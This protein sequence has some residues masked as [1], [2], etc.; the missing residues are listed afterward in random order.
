MTIESGLRREEPVAFTESFVNRALEAA[1]ELRDA[2]TSRS[3]QSTPRE[4]SA[5]ARNESGAQWRRN[6]LAG[7]FAV[8]FFVLSLYW[9]EP[10]WHDKGH[11]HLSKSQESS[12]QPL[13]ASSS[14]SVHKP[15]EPDAGR[16]PVLPV[17]NQTEEAPLSP[18]D[19]FAA[20]DEEMRNAIAQL[21]KDEAGLFIASSLSKASL[22]KVTEGGSKRGPTDEAAAQRLAALT[23][24]KQQLTRETN[25][26][27]GPLEADDVAM[28][29][30]L[31]HRG[32][33]FDHDI[34]GIS[35]W[36]ARHASNAASAT[37]GTPDDDATLFNASSQPR[38]VRDLIREK[39]MFCC[40]RDAH[41]LDKMEYPYFYDYPTGPVCIP[42]KMGG[43]KNENSGDDMS[44]MVSLS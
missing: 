13:A 44:R 34:L 37:A 15:A 41:D 14:V 27:F 4:R 33:G 12:R 36:A 11:W 2:K 30:I 19:Q 10:G 31:H 32:G 24:R 43:G 17:P 35:A 29:G 25:S 1:E 38:E 28:D 22:L 7:A 20:D 9:I 8:A 6:A 18:E 26:D 40:I 3:G 21:D 42:G 5:R 16:L 39:I 23:F